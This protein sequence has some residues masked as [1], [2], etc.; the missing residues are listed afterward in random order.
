V[1][2]ILAPLPYFII[3]EVD[4][5]AL[6]NQIH[7]YNLDTSCFYNESEQLIHKKL[8]KLY[9]FRKK[10]RK[11]N[12]K[13]D[14]PAKVAKYLT[15]ANRRIGKLKTTLQEEFAKNS[16]LRDLNKQSLTQY[17]VISIFES[18]LTRKIGI[19]TNS[20]S[21]DIMVVR[22][23]YFDI[24]RDLMFYGFMLD[25]EKYVYFSSSAGQIRTKKS[26]FIKESVLDECRNSLTCGLSVARI[27]ELG[28]VN[29]N[30]YLSYLALCNSA[31]DVW[32]DFDISKA[33]VVDDFS[34]LVPGIVDFIDDK[35]YSVTRK[36]MDV[37]IEHTDGCGMVLPRKCRA[38]MMVRLPWVKGLLSPF[39]FDLMVE[40]ANKNSDGKHYGKVVDIYGKEWDILK[41]NIEVI[42][43]R[44]QFKMHKHYPNEVDEKGKVIK[45]GW[46]I[47]KENFI[48]YRCEAAKCSEEDTVFSNSR[49]CYQMLQTLTDISQDELEKLCEKTKGNIINIGSDKNTMLRVLGVTEYNRNKNY[50]QQAIEVYPELLQDDY[51]KDV[52]KQIKKSLVYSGRSGKIEINAKYTYVIPDL[53]AFCEWLFF[54][55]ANPDGLLK[56]GEVFCKLYQGK[57]KL[58]CLRS[59]HLYREHAIRKNVVD[60]NKKKWFITNGVYLSCHDLVSK[61]LQN[62]F[63]GDNL[64]IVAEDLFIN[65]AE[66]NMSDIVPLYYKMANAKAEIISSSTL[67]N[68]LINAY[69]GGNIGVV[70][71]NITKIWNSNNVNLEVIKLLCMENNF[72]ID[73]AKTLYKPVRP[74][75][76]DKIVN[77][78]TKNKLPHF[79][80]Y[81]KDKRA[82]DVAKNNDSTVN[83]LEKII[84]NK[85]IKFSD[86]GIGDFDYKMLMID[87]NVDLKIAKA[88]KII[89]TYKELDLKKFSM[90]NRNEIGDDKDRIGNLISLYQ[91][92]REKI[93]SLDNNVLYV[94]DVLVEYLYGEIHAR[95]KTTL[96]ECF[97]GEI[98][99]NLK[100]KISTSRAYCEQCGVLIEKGSNRSKYC[101]DCAKKVQFDQKKEWDK[102]NRIGKSEN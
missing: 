84:P 29:I 14:V 7:I 30:K 26:V 50:L 99:D 71:N 93:L 6:K 73:Y 16:G 92:I 1:C 55:N 35:D 49:L 19:E 96:W 58:N 67:Y 72:V 102:V 82:K 22:T 46:D 34:T 78:Y 39:P 25:G 89:S 85:R 4:L 8:S 74:K 21:R 94:V 101:S 87:T 100:F 31:T 57:S 56:N 17:N 51:C 98:V 44:S 95:H 64:L 32:Q 5:L 68:G 47:Y 83:K 70:S 52:L 11:L 79:F 53:Y 97:G 59:P 63:D 2:F 24:L 9:S 40:E 88:Q 90:I 38:N 3:Q 13:K 18:T 65:V 37:P 10:L 15:N 86:V 80:V 60:K 66:R 41:D 23:Y 76:K 54:G 91:N 33:I 62:D 27:N 20:L 48:K 36:N 61:I 75:C 42:F 77:S 43:C 12:E 81:A 69:V 45:Y 28:G